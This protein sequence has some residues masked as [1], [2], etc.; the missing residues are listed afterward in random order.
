AVEVVGLDRAGPPGQALPRRPAAA[1]FATYR[2]LDEEIA[3][4]AGVLFLAGEIDA[5]GPEAGDAFA[6]RRGG[7][8]R[9]R[10]RLQRRLG[11]IGQVHEQLGV[12]PPGDVRHRL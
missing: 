8:A 3:P 2:L 11:G 7:D 10:C 6:D 4:P 12:L 5:R 9:V 1:P